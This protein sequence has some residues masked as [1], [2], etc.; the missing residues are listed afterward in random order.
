MALK[1][2]DPVV[3]S[4]ISS[5]ESVFGALF[6]WLILS[7]KMNEREIAGAIII[8]LA[9]LLAQLPIEVYLKKKLEGR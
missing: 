4:M 2:L 1:E 5:L 6:G 8:F 3:A 7:Q 9:T